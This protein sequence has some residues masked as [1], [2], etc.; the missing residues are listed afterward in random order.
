MK[1]IDLTFQA[2]SIAGN[3]VTMTFAEIGELSIEDGTFVC[4]K[5]GVGPVSC[6]LGTLCICTSPITMIYDERQRQVTVEGFS[7]EYDEQWTH[8]ELSAAA[9]CY[10]LSESARFTS[11]APIELLW[12]WA[13]KW[14]KPSPDDRKKELVKAAALIVSDLDRILRMEHLIE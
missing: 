12:P 7:P 5:S 6:S 9:A 13:A 1:V 4:N 8:G 14:W 2:E 3:L 10:A 11:E